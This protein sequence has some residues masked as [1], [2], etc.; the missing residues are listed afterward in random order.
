L[1]NNAHVK[2][3][4]ALLI[5]AVILG[6]GI[7][8]LMLPDTFGVIGH[9]RAD[10]LK[11]I[12]KLK[13]VYQG[14]EACAPCHENSAILAKDVHFA[15]QCENCHGPGNIHIAQIELVLK[16][17]NLKPDES[18]KYPKE[19]LTVISQKMAQ[20]PKEYTLEGCL[21]CHRKLD[22][23]PRD[24]AQVDPKEHY[25]FLHVTDNSI[26]CV[27]C[28]NPHEPLFLLDPVSNAR[29]HP[30][31]FECEQCHKERP[32]KSDKDVANHPPV[33][34]CED[35]HAA[36]VHDFKKREH[37]F[38]RCT[39]CHL[40]HRENDE[41]GRIYKNSNKQFCLLCHEKKPFKDQAKLPQIDVSK[42]LEDMPQAMRK[43]AKSIMN[44]QTA[45]MECHYNFI[46]DP[47]LIRILREQKQWA[48]KA[49]L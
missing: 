17:K 3:I 39:Q 46:H 26:R 37:A 45:C 1:K 16:Q 44:S 33:F 29:I 13:R 19:T 8:Q 34:G 12:L 22:S 23:R 47:E 42:H 27:E 10:S 30:T 5:I 32:K 49:I 18:G 15:V 31:I 24:F 7:R 4:F 25:K 43:D 36:I 48:K 21:Y 2:R 38:M 28:H 14:K 35:C 6:F 20:M 11:D 41:S 40:F 9:Y